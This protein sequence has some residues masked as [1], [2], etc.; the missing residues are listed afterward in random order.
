MSD[1]PQPQQPAPGKR[2][3]TGWRRIVPTWR[4]TLGAFLAGALLLTGGFFLGYHLVHI[5]SANA[6]AIKQ[7]NVYLYTD[8]S[9]IARDGEVNRENVGLG[10]ISQD[11][12]HAILAAEDRDFYTESAVDPQAMLRA[13]IPHHTRTHPLPLHRPRRGHR[14]RPGHGRG[15]RDPRQPR[16]A[17]RLHHDREDHQG[18]RETVP[19]PERKNRR[20]VSREAADT[21]TAVLRGVVRNG[22]ATAALGAGRPAAGKTGTAEEDKAAWFAGYTPELATVVAVMG[23]NPDTAVQEKLYGAMGL[24]RINGG[25]VPAEIWAQFTREALE[26][27]PVSDFDLELQPDAERTAPPTAD[28]GSRPPTT[29][30]GDDTPATPGPDENAPRNPGPDDSTGG[31][32][33]EGGTNEGTGGDTTTGGT[34][35]DT[36]T[37]GTTDGTTG[38]GTTGDTD[39][40][41][42]ARPT[43]RTPARAAAA[44][45]PASSHAPAG[46]ERTRGP[47]AHDARC[48]MLSAPTSPSAPPRRPPA[49]TRRRSGRRSPAPP[50]PPCPAPPPRR[51]RSPPTRRTPYRSAASSPRTTAAPCSPRCR[52]R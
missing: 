38:G 1:E 47:T 18:R 26:G 48:R 40:G 17:Q 4:M 24:P 37:G 9:V 52:H 35:G 31:G 6:L 23:Q 11:A 25:G 50:A 36:S 32:R 20:A 2:N 46:S 39:S 34:D 45:S 14:Q 16:R 41:E 49:G 12:Q 33:T 43:A 21:T 28:A 30:P 51:H 29:A 15:V 42:P 3:R 13:G 7:A 5:P 44:A 10:R 27:E 19:L 22:T 8:G